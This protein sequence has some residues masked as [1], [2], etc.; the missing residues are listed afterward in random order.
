MFQIQDIYIYIYIYIYID[1]WVLKA[2]GDIKQFKS[3]ENLILGLVQVS[4]SSMRKK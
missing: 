4:S 1:F 3:V 2:F